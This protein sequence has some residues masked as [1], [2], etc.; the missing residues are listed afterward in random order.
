MPYGED[1]L[2]AVL[3]RLPGPSAGRV[4]LVCIEGLGGSGK[5]SLARQ[6]AARS[7]DITLVHGDD[8]YG[9]EERDWRSWTPQQGYERY[10]DHQRVERELLRPLRAGQVARFQRYDW[11]SNTLDGWVSVEPRGVVLV[12]GVYLL[13]RELRGYWDFSVY[14]DTPRELRQARL[15]ARGENDAGWIA[16]WAAAEDYYEQAEQPAQAADLVVSGY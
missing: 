10:F 1:V 4:S 11:E 12:E 5:T 16:R 8:F 7:A 15:Y 14:V 3:S 6:L 9:P 13:R 2:T